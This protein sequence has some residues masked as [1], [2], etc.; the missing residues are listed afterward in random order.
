[1]QQLADKTFIQS[2]RNRAGN[3]KDARVHSEFKPYAVSLDTSANAH[4]WNIHPTRHLSVQYCG[5]PRCGICL[6]YSSLQYTPILKH[7]AR[8]LSEAYNS[9]GDQS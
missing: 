7:Q 3:L 9:E 2:Y 8:P 4:R 5:N 6:R 1:M